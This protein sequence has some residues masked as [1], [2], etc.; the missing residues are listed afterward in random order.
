MRTTLKKAESCHI[1]NKKYIN[2]DIIVRDHCHITKKCWGSAHQ[3]CN[4]NFKLTDKIPIT[5]HNLR[6]YDRFSFYYAKFG[7]IAKKHT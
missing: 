1:C 4:L 6:G 7:E 5:F 2:K 3:D